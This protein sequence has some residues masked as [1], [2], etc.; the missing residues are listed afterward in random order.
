[1]ILQSDSC[2][3][4]LSYIARD[5]SALRLRNVAMNGLQESTYAKTMSRYASYLDHRILGFRELGYD[6]I[7]TVSSRGVRLRHLPVAKGLLRETSVIQKVTRSVLE[8]SFFSEDRL[9]ELTMAAL[10]MVLKDLLVLYMV[11]NEG[12]INILGHYF[13][14]SKPDA[15]RALELY[16]RFVWQT[17]KV[18][19]YLKATRKVSYGLKMSV[20]RLQHAPVSLASSLEEYLKDPNFER[21]REEYIRKKKSGQTDAK[22]ATDDARSSPAPKDE[23]P[24]KGA[25]EQKATNDADKEPSARVPP[26]ASGNK[27]L[28]DFFEALEGGQS[29]AFNSAYSFG[30][31]NFNAMFMAPQNTGA[32]SSPFTNG[33]PFMTPQVG[34]MSTPFQGPYTPLMPQSTGNPFTP[35]QPQTTGNPFAQFQPTPAL[36]PMHTGMQIPMQTGILGSATPFD[37]IFGAQSAPQFVPSQPLAQPQMPPQ[38]QPQPMPQPQNSSSS[39]YAAQV[40]DDFLGT[41]PS[42]SSKDAPS[43]TAQPAEAGTD[44][45]P[46]QAPDSADKTPQTALRPQKTGFQNPFSIPSDFEPPPEPP[47]PKGPTLHELA[48]DAWT[49]TSGTDKHPSQQA[50][51][52]SQPP[53]GGLLAQP[54]GMASVASEFVRPQATGTPE[55]ALEKGMQNLQ[56]GAQP[57]GFPQSLTG[58]GQPSLSGQTQSAPLQS[59]PTGL[60]T[61]R[62]FKPESQFGNSLTSNPMFASP[63]QSSVAQIGNP[64]GQHPTT[65]LVGLGIGAN[66]SAVPSRAGSLLPGELPS[67]SPRQ[68]T[69]LTGTPD[70]RGVPLRSSSLVPQSTGANLLTAQTTTTGTSSLSSQPT[71]SSAF[72][73]SA[74]LLPSGGTMLPQTT[75]TQLS[76]LSGTPFANAFH[77]PRANS[78]GPQPSSLSHTSQPGLGVQSTGIA[79]LKP[80]QPTSAFGNSLKNQPQTQDLLQL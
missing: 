3:A 14:M 8:C 47:A 18:V 40:V 1:M 72:S 21:N 70:L 45:Q 79:D 19:S 26:A 62:T 71:G 24:A 56:L 42:S 50:Q 11:V 60:S 41:G 80:F 29:N 51:E 27:A 32:F 77:P 22:S 6:P 49:R 7:A 38:M 20:P 44:R 23:A 59:Q 76:Q 57:T 78:L 36:Q 63:A 4:V 37:S 46:T 33:M 12:V 74:A 52:T 31:P 48:M 66:P 28:E 16:K 30:G 5:P 58:N 73:S 69:L 2:T 34:A 15:E 10:H 9:D 61:L 68:N 67:A 13:E 39:A 65:P 75:G 25:E 53:T 64:F 43:S 54:T 17:D 35:L 55:N